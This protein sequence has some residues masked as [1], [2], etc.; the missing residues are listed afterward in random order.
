MVDT[1]LSHRTHALE[2][3]ILQ[4]LGLSA[5]TGGHEGA[6]ILRGPHGGSGGRSS[7][8]IPYALVTLHRPGNVDHPE[9]FKGILDALIQLAREVPVIFPV[10]PRTVGRIKEYGFGAYC[11]IVH[12]SEAISNEQGVLHC[13]EPL[14][15]KRGGSR[16]FL[17]CGM[18]RPLGGSSPF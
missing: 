5:R 16:A 13:I 1:L 12:G 15:G 14:R 4:R 2:S 7:V 10:H 6:I 8:V 9:T 18:E 3:T 17:R 11:R